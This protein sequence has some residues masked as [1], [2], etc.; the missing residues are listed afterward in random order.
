MM[1]MRE[2]DKWHVVIPAELAYGKRSMGQHITPG[3]VLV[4]E[5]ELVK[6]HG[7]GEANRWNILPRFFHDI[8]FMV[9]LC[10]AYFLYTLFAGP[11]ETIEVHDPSLG[12]SGEV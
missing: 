7:E 11:L 5:M 8:P 3:S 10:L 4:F 2:G 6:V 12:T 1:K 9:W